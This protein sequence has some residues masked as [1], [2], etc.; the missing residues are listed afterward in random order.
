[1][2]WIEDSTGPALYS[3]VLLLAQKSSV[4]C[5]WQQAAL[6]VCMGAAGVTRVSWCS[7]L[8][9]GTPV[10]EYVVLKEAQCVCDL[11]QEEGR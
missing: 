10:G 8:H 6:M 3:A 9:V 5:G 1:M 2:R 7:Q 11:W 4:V